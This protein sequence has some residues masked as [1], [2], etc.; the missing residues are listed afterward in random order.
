MWYIAKTSNGQGL[1]IDDKT[2]ENIAVTYKEENAPIVASAPELLRA[3]K[4]ALHAIAECDD[5]SL[6]IYILNHAINTAEG[7]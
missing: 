2:G 6:A 3:C 7:K 5:D 1:I 4:D